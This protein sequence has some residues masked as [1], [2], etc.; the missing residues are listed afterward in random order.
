MRYILDN[1]G[2]IYHV[3]FGGYIMCDL[4]ECTEY[5]GEIPDGYETLNEWHDGELERLNAWKIVDGNLVFDASKAAEI[6]ERCEQQEKDNSYVTHKEIEAFRV[7]Q[8]ENLKELYD[9]KS[10]ETTH[11]NR[12]NTVNNSSN[13]QVEKIE[14]RTTD[15]GGQSESIKLFFTTANMLPNDLTSCSNGGISFTQNEDKSIS[16]SGTSTDDVE[17]SLASTPT[18][19]ESIF[20]F[21]EGVNYLLNGLT[22]GVS[23]KFYDYDGTDRTLIGEYTDGSIITWEEDKKVTQITLN[24]PNGTTINETI[25]PMLQ[26]VDQLQ[27]DSGEVTPYEAY[28]GN[29]LKVNWDGNLISFVSGSK[30]II[31]NGE[32]TLYSNYSVAEGEILEPDEEGLG[33]L[34]F[35]FPDDLYERLPR[36]DTTIVQFGTVLPRIYALDKKIYLEHDG[37]TYTLYDNEN[38]INLTSIE[39][40]LQRWYEITSLDYDISDYINLVAPELRQTYFLDFVTMPKTYYRTTNIYSDENVLTRITYRNIDKINTQ[41]IKIGTFV[42]TDEG[43]TSEIAPPA[44]YTQEDI[45]KASNY[46]IDISGITEEEFEKYDLNKDGKISVADVSY[47]YSLMQAKATTTEPALLEINSKNPLKTLLIQDN[48]GNEVVN[49][50]LTS[51]TLPKLEVPSITVNNRKYGEQKVLWEGAYLMKGSQ[52]ATLSEPISS[53]PNGII[54][55]WSNYA[56]DTV[57]DEGFTFFFVPKI[58]VTLQNGKGMNCPIIHHKFDA[59]INK[60]VY[61]YDDKITGND[62]NNAT[63]SAKG[64]TYATNRSVLRYVIGV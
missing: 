20:Y 10:L 62:M 4:G 63:G 32:A 57:K 28:K 52:T 2:Y 58:F 33:T 59:I 1:E 17:V 47:M 45:T 27:I 3:S 43:L 25:Y 7:E 54:L 30:I 40:G 29:S 22:T 16:I 53:Q 21:L 55:V 12:L 11:L 46:S 14:I 61:I 19:T 39:I 41:K 5:N 36:T 26:D 51:A 35:D 44:D 60:Y 23:V 15:G 13:M 56:D 50:N 6:Q 42:I 9:E 64:I 18:N 49:I 37:D 48:E 31:E 24:I 8:D 38:D 34:Y